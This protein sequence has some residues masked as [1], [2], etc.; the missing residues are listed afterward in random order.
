IHPR[1]FSARAAF[2]PGGVSRQR[3]MTAFSGSTGGGAAGTIVPALFQLRSGRSSQPG[4]AW[5]CAFPATDRSNTRAMYLMVSLINL[6][7][8]LRSCSS[9]RN[10]SVAALSG[11]ALLVEVGFSPDKVQVVVPHV[12][13]HRES[14]T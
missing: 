7:L 9:H 1:A 8:V 3:L 5:A 11:D 4:G 14:R 6:Q 12:H 13:R 10:R 2:P